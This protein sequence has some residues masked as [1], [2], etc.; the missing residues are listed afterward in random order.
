L[1]EGGVILMR[2]KDPH[3]SI[4]AV[5]DMVDNTPSSDSW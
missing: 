1:F 3:P 2:F 5:Q 4:G